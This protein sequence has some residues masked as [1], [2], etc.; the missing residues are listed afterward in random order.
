MLLQSHYRTRSIKNCQYWL[1]LA[2]EQD[3]ETDLDL[4]QNKKSDQDK[5]PD[6]N[7]RNLHNNE[8]GTGIY[9]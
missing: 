7:P 8:S 3:P 6:Q 2:F 1:G 4:Y 5:D 9:K